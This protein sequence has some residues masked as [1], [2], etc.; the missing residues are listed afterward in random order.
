MGDAGRLRGGQHVEMGLVV[1]GPGVAWRAGAGGHAR[2][3][4]AELLAAEA[5]AGDGGGVGQ[6]YGAGLGA[7]GVRAT[8][9]DNADDVMAAPG[10]CLQRGAA[11][12]AGGA[13]EANAG[14][15]G[16]MGGHWVG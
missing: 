3:H 4:S 12:R 1:D 16:C 7:G 5:V 13:E 14:R 11:D 9:A 15:D 10:E 8:G 6:V 2:Y